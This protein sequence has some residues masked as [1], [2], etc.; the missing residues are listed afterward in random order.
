[1]LKEEIVKFLMEYG[2][3]VIFILIPIIVLMF[4]HEI[5]KL[6]AIILIAFKKNMSSMRT[7]AIS[8]I[9]SPTTIIF[10]QKE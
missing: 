1:M 6:V 7:E 3:I 8:K 5:N 2:Y 4:L 9:A 10:K